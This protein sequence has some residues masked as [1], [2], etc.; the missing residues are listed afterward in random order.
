MSWNEGL[1]IE[2]AAYKLAADNSK[3]IRVVAGPGTGKSFSLRRRVARLLEEGQDPKRVL[4][5]TFTRT[6]AQDLR[7]EIQALNVEGA[8]DVVAKTLHSF[9]FSLL[10]KQD[11]ISSSGRTPRVVLDFEKKPMLCDINSKFGNAREKKSRLQAF[12]AAWARLQSEEPGFPSNQEDADFQ[13]EIYQW[14]TAHKAMLFGEMIIEA[15]HYLAN[16]P[17]CFERHQFDHLLVDEYQDLNKAEQAVIDLLSTNSSLLIIGDDDQSIYSFKCANPEGIR[18]F[19]HTHSDCQE[20]DFDQ[21]RRCPKKVVKMASHLISHNPNRTLGELLSFDRNQEGN[22][23]VYQWASLDEEIKNISTI[24]SR[25]IQAGEILPED[26]LVLAP[27]R[28][29][30]YRVRDELIQNGINAKSYFREAALHT[31]KQKQRF[32][33]LTLLVHPDDYVALRYLLGTGNQTF[34]T[35]SYK[36]LL[37]YSQDK[38]ISTREVLEKCK[39]REIKVSG[40][41]SLVKRYETISHTLEQYK[42]QLAVNREALIDLLTDADDEEDNDLRSVIMESIESANEEREIEKWLEAVYSYSLEKVSHPDDTSSK[43]HVRIMSLHA[44]KGLSARY[45]VVMSAVDELIPRIKKDDKVSIDKQIEEQ[46]RLFY[47]AITRVKSSQSGYPGTLVISSFVG[48][49]GIAAVGIGIKANTHYWKTTK[50]TRFL[51]DFNG[52]L[53]SIRTTI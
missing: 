10:N 16:N 49:P 43:D 21:C 20:I 33:L 24:I 11:I 1:D 5:V 41:S 39:S 8:N 52:L 42:T 31:E 45:V 44:S 14:L 32:E 9:C 4:A 29:I 51:K 30:G 13:K 19:S 23:K 40:I 47:V 48:L 17:M 36:K 25:K 50:S 7:D 18:D 28:K 6:A 26:V 15:Y 35:A 27:V 2:S 53:P 34:R 3:T 46:R 38:N 12:E 22:V 37:L